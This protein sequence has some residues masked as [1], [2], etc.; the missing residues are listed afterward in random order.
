[1]MPGCLIL[2]PQPEILYPGN[3]HHVNYH[4]I[5][6][7]PR[8]CCRRLAASNVGLTVDKTRAFLKKMAAVERM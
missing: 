2:E 5:S 1:M 7:P 4:L 6:D 8:Q 3:A